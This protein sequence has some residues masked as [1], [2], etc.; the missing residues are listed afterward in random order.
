MLGWNVAGELPY[1]LVAPRGLDPAVQHKL[2]DAFRQAMAEPRHD[3]L[4][5]Q[6]NV[7]PWPRSSAE[8]R[9]WAE[10]RFDQE[11]VLLARLGL[12]AR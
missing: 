2:H 7:D 5:E 9:A 8:F 12:L 3:V 4:M 6:L 1:G 10:T 11:R